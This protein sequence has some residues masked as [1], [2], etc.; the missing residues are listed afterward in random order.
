ME[1]IKKQKQKGY[2]IMA[3]SN[4]IP[5]IWSENLYTQLD[6]QYIAVANCNR[7]FEGDIRDKGSVV[8]ICGV[9]N[10]NISSYTKNTDMSSAQQ[11]SDTVRE[12][13]IDQARYFNFQIDDI[14]RAQA[15]PKLMSAA[16]KNAASALANDA[17]N[18]VFSLYPKSSKAVV[19][20]DPSP[21][22]IIGY[23]IDAITNLRMQNVT[24]PNDIVIEVS[25]E[26]AALI[27][28]AKINL[29]TDGGETLET[30]CIGKIAGCKIFVSNNIVHIDS[31]ES[32]KH[33]CFVRSKRAIA[34]AEQISEIEAYR[35]EKRFSDAVKG[36]HLYGADVVYPNEFLILSVNFNRK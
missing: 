29:A 25:P 30:G 26:V 33:C 13:N 19:V 27:I 6:K 32:V 18:Y 15:S 36:L 35:P 11:L 2:F 16:M 34:F 22:N 12:L 4:F 23:V 31:E 24:D 7:E 14:D 10:I 5:T 21:D 9:G 17:D 3:I 1:L 20:N 8:K 28:K